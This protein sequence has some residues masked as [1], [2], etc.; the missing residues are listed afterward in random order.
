MLKQIGDAF[1]RDV[2]RWVQRERSLIG[3]MVKKQVFVDV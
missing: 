2:H 3:C 1:N